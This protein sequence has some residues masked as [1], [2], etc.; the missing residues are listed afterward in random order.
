M[1][2]TPKVYW[3]DGQITSVENSFITKSQV[4]II[5]GSFNPLHKSHQYIYHQA[6]LRLGEVFFELSITNRH[7]N[8][9][10]IRDLNDRI[11]QFSWYAPLIVS[12]VPRFIDKYTLYRSLMS[13]SSIFKTI[14]FWIGL[15]T[16]N[17]LV[18]DE[19]IL[20]IESMA[21]YFWVSDRNVER[22]ERYPH[23]FNFFDQGKKSK[24]LMEISSTLLRSKKSENL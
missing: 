6:K 2:S 1:L 21:C 5:P 17:R 10:E 16:A 19:G 23:N 14:N 9:I 13:Q 11:K 20:D 15:D 4:N 3:P 24:E 22:L 7:K 12:D 8:P 18:Q